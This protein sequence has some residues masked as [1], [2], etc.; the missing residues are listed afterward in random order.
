MVYCMWQWIGQF[1]DNEYFSVRAWNREASGGAPCFH[2][3]LQ[4]AEY[5]GDIGHCPDGT[6]YWNVTVV[7]NVG[8][9]W[10]EV[11][12]A[13]EERWFFFSSTARLSDTPLPTPT[14]TP[15]ETPTPFTTPTATPTPAAPILSFPENGHHF[16]G[17]VTL[18]WMWI[19]ELEPDE[20][21]DLRGWE[22]GD[23]RLCFHDHTRDTEYIGGVGRCTG[24][25]LWLVCVVRSPTE[26]PPWEEISGPSDTGWFFYSP[27]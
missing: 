14:N 25:V 9:S 20:Y 11:S 17:E 27:W 4:G 13:S 2:A 21:F 15:T 19:R 18:S 10:I 5:I 3:Q 6:I 1:E 23:D 12:E 16:R 7:R 26:S 24:R 8:D 22:E